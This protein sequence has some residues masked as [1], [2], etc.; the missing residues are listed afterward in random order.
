MNTEPP[1]GEV[2]GSRLLSAADHQAPGRRAL[3]LETITRVV[4]PSV[5]LVAV[6]LF[7]AGLHHPGGGFAAG[8]IAG[9]GLALRRFAGG[10][11]ELGVAAPLQPGVLLGAGL[12]LAAGYGLAGVVLAD[13]FLAGTVWHVTV[14]PL[15][16]VEIAASLV[17]EAGIALIVI[18]LVLDILRTL[19]ARERPDTPEA[20]TPRGGTR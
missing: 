5:L 7:L 6:Y 11:R 2:P 20:S 17:F 18:G 9:L 14:G 3:L 1:S 15:G 16:A 10:P 13:E 8:L 12:T 19:G 4:H